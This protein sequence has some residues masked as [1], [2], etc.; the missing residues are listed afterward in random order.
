ME[1]T[2]P[3]HLASEGVGF[4][5]MRD[6]NKARWAYDL[7]HPTS[8]FMN[9]LGT[10]G[11]VNFNIADVRV[12]TSTAPSIPIPATKLAYM[13]INRLSGLL[14]PWASVEDAA[15]DQ[16]G[17]IILKALGKEVSTAYRQWPDQDKPHKVTAMRCG[18]CGLLTLTY[19]PPRFEGDDTMIDCPCGYAL[20][21][22]GFAWAVT[23]IE[24]E[25]HERM[26]AARK[27]RKTA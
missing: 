8:S 27:K 1:N 5:D 20:N 12:S 3:A 25:E 7:S 22:D 24:K 14:Q 9:W 11:Q 4:L 21:D 15:H 16:E 2:E 26:E 23:M 19:R 13:E 17:A 18:R 6:Y 10:A